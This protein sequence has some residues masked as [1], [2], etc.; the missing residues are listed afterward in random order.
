MQPI[1]RMISSM[2]SGVFWR[3]KPQ[4]VDRDSSCIQEFIN[5]KMQTIEVMKRVME[6]AS[7][8]IVG[9]HPIIL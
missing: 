6:L 1:D 4:F 3:K 9:R 5:G 8:P 2:G 7:Y